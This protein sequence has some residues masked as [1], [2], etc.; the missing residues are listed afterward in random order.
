MEQKKPY[1]GNSRPMKEVKLT[2]ESAPAETRAEGYEH[3]CFNYDAVV[4]R[5]MDDTVLANRLIHKLAERI[6]DDLERLR[7]ALAQADG[8][9]LARLAHKLKGAAANLEVE[10]IMVLAKQ[11][12]Q[13]GRSGELARATAVFSELEQSA[14]LYR[15]EARA[16]LQQGGE[17]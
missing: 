12:E 10:S 2:T 16:L 5:C 6:E 4:H 13:M 17:V 8:D 15:D 11:L 7:E 9:E 1:G 3:I 14:E